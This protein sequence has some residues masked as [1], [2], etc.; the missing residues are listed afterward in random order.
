MKENTALSILEIDNEINRYIGWPGQAISYKLGELK[1]K[2]LRK[3]SET[4]LGD[5]F[6][7]SEFHDQILS[8][9]SV[10]LTTLERI[11][12]NWVTEQRT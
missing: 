7:I 3:Y 4:E 9:G 6:E 10:P 8:N 11:I 1:I 2:E 5:N 12:K